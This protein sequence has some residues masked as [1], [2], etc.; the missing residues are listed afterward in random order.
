MPGYVKF[1]IVMREFQVDT[2]NEKSENVC[3]YIC[4]C[5]YIYI[6]CV[7]YIMYHMISYINVYH[8]YYIYNF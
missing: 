6:K 7:T 4:A 3:M 1:M 8:I 5:V 2:N